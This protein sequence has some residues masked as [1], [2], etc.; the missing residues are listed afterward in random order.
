MRDDVKFH[1]GELITADDVKFSI[2]TNM[3]KDLKYVYG[4]TFRRLFERGEVVGPH[5][6]RLHLKAPAQAIFL[7]FWWGAS[8]YPKKYREAVGDK[9]FASKPIGAGPFKWV[10]YK[11][12]QWFQLE[13]V[14]RHHRKVPEIKTL[15]FVFVPE[16]STRLAMLKTKEGDIVHL[17]A[18]HVREAMKLPGVQIKYSKYIYGSVLAYADLAF[19]DVPSPFHDI[20]VREAASLAIDRKTITDKIL[21]GLAEPYGEQISPVSLGWDST[22]KPDPYDPERA[23]ALLKEAGYPKGF[24]TTLNI[25]T[26]SLSGQAIAANLNEVGIRAKLKVFEGGAFAAAFRGKKLTGL[27]PTQSWYAAEKEAPADMMSNN[28][29]GSTWTYFVPDDVNKAIR[30]GLTAINDDD[31]EVAGRNISKLARASRFK[32]YLWSNTAAVGLG[33]KIKFYEPQIGGYPPSHYD[34]ITANR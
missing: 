10:D 25:T 34:Y 19:P 26:G 21:F 7:R 9:D 8:I 30:K 18:P 31:L 1:N 33:P 11:Q 27:V 2:D 32:L 28:L 13:A 20:R 24:D 22:V 15:K 6:F 4:G 29:R 14:T 17:A 23:K 5:H 16:N 3:R 12:D